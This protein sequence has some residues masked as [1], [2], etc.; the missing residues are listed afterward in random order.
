MY[1]RFSCTIGTGSFPGVKS[2]RGVTL[3]PHPLLVPWSRKNRIIT[4]LP[5][6]AVRPVQSLSACTRVHFTF[7]LPLFQV[8]IYT[9]LTYYVIT[10]LTFD[11][12]L[13]DERHCRSKHVARVSHICKLLSFH[14][15]AV[16]CI[17]TLQYLFSLDD[18]ISSLLN[19]ARRHL[20]FFNGLLTVRLSI[21]LVI[22]QLDA[23]ILVL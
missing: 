14:C 4:L 21:I 12:H 2:G 16:W 8:Y 7:T 20:L 13:P 1:F 6:W 5:L 19:K 9:S 18:I 17:N 10:T 3:T 23:Q 22:N 11:N 15:W